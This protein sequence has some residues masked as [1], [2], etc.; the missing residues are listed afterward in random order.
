MRLALLFL[1]ILF[2]SHSI[3]AQ[4]NDDLIIKQI[5]RM[6]ENS[7][8]ECD[9]SETI[10][11]YWE[12][13]DN[14]ININSD[15]IE[16]LADLKFL[17]VFQ[18]ENIK[19]YRKDFGDILFID[20][21]YEV[22]GLDTLSIETIKPLICF[23]STNDDKVRLKDIAKYGRN[24]IILEASQCLNKKKGYIDKEGYLGSPQRIYLRYNYSSRD[25]I[26]AGFVLEKD[27]GEHILSRN[28]NDSIRRLLG[29]RY[30]SGFDFISFHAVIKDIKF[31]KTLA[32][33]DYKLSFGQGL[34]MGSGMAF[35]SDGGSLIR[36]NK[37]ISAS[38]SANETYYLRGIAS[39]LRHNNFELSIFY[40]NK[41]TD[42]NVIAYDSLNEEPLEISSLQQNGL[43]RTFNEIID[44]K[45]IQQQLYGLNLSY[46]NSKFQLGYTLH[47]THLNA[48]I[49]PEYRFHNT[50]HFRGKILSNQSIDA[51]YI[52]DRI[53]LY[54]ELAM[55]DNKGLAGLF[56][57][58]I[59]PTGY[60]EFNILYRNYAKDY[61]CL[62]SNAYANGSGTR[63]EK[64]FYLSSTI[65]IASNWK[66]ITNF[67]C[68]KSDW[69]KSTSYSPSH[70]YEF[71]AQLNYQPDK[72]TLLFIEYRNKEKSRNTS[73]SVYQKYLTEEMTN[74]IR[75]HVSYNIM[76][77]I[78]LKNRV[79]YHFN[80][81]EDD[82]HHSYLMY[83]DII[84]NSPKAYS[85]AFRYELFNAEKGSV[86]TYE[87]DILYSFGL[88][89][90]S[91]KGV[92]TYLVGKVKL[93]EQLQLS[94]KIGFTFYHDKDKIS[95]GL[96]TI[97]GNC[98][99]DGKLQIIWSF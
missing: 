70:G 1:I 79:E 71:D 29:D 18:I 86:Y 5:E 48:A 31:I 25:K 41:K 28:I 6:S 24:K 99:G 91:D 9:Y 66:F 77:N 68:H 84:Y 39:T 58:T 52:F 22:E 89:S 20:E 19:K 75:F 16:Q 92:R 96:E 10:E 69:F 47:Q 37:K 59:Q 93:W 35:V 42:G 49:N 65:S 33:G 83:Q 88:N 11:T 36:R 21:L 23:Q 60:I 13:T 94:C 26:E 4:T 45:A 64:G 43:H 62:Y 61:Q 40:S 34:C 8:G 85:I 55:S 14:T 78:T 17:N 95:S 38:K 54:G 46:R 27:P 3:N 67:D 50:F 30:Y 15:D 74:T 7:E 76:N 32:I 81:Y 56:G 90:L 73:N 87:N 82:Q 97:E 80:K 98:K 2:A 57:T 44:R 63:N 53:I 72:N 51:Y 12:I